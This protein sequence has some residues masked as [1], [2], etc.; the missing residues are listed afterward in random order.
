M[1]VRHKDASKMATFEVIEESPQ[2]YI[3][4]YDGCFQAT[5]LLPK[6]E[7]APVQEEQQWE[8]VSAE[9]IWSDKTTVC[10]ERG[11][12]TSLKHRIICCQNLP[13]GY[14]L[15]KVDIG[16]RPGEVI[17][18]PATFFRVEKKVE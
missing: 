16:K 2:H 6:S 15:V 4:K 18:I 8:D 9:F 14:R 7:F 12:W 10:D 3:A 11:G 17:P 13:D 1:K 5:I